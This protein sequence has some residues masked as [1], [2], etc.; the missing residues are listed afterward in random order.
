[1]KKKIV[2][3]RFF[4]REKWRIALFFDYDKNLKS[5]VKSIPGATYSATHRCF[6]VDDSEENL[7]LI[8][9]RLRD[10]VAIDI[11]A[12]TKKNGDAER[13]ID[14]QKEVASAK[15]SPINQPFED[16]DSETI[17]YPQT[18]QRV[19]KDEDDTFETESLGRFGSVEFRI[20]EA[21]GLLVIRFL[22]RYD[23]E[24]IDELRSFGQCNFDKRRKE[25]LLPWSKMTTDSLADYFAGRRVKVNITKQ[26]VNE[27][28]RTERKVTGDEIRSRSLG[29]KALDGLDM[30]TWY[31]DENRY[32]PRTRESYLAMLE[33]FFRYF[34]SVEPVD[35][36]EEDISKFLYDFI[37][38]LGYSPTYQNQ[39]VSA[40][41]I[42]YTI[43]GKGKVDPDFLE[44]P[45]RRRSLPKVFSKEEVS[46]I[47]NSSGNLKH[48]LLLWI[49]YSCGLRRSEV[50][51]I[52][53]TDLDRE[54]NILHIREGKGRVD[55]FVPVPDK[56]WVKLNEYTSAYNPR[57]YL[58]EGQTGG[59]Y[60][61]ESV[62]RVFKNALV[63]A[64][65]KKD[66]GVHSLRHSYATH[67]HENGLDIRYIQELLGHR[68]TRTTEIYTHV[69]RRNLIAVRSPID[70]LDV[71]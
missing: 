9:N 1:M 17:H 30:L 42:Y 56:V 59:R 19:V 38:R 31:L 40:I 22:G 49:I 64:G 62:Y 10:I 43:S 15:P 34:S 57:E 29:K 67:L 28:L 45:R 69:S 33:F 71:K 2:L 16:E 68:S 11:S 6:Y 41:K 26:L 50:T 58:F 24:W 37:I 65:I 48:K 66:V 63:K 44:R 4:H 5:K 54:R 47:L 12:L 70:D 21:E 8:L 27:K 35:I 60:S 36:T 25:W 61:S 14:P 7:K 52:R 13:S 3:K 20:S 53:L 23:P 18:I 32:S 55:R 39:M 51:N 46:S